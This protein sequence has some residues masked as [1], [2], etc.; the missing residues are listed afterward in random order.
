MV[1]GGEGETTPAE[2]YHISSSATPP[3]PIAFCDQGRPEQTTENSGES[4]SLVS[5]TTQE[6]PESKWVYKYAELF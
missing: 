3:L 4:P 1:E 5:C 2:G 6:S